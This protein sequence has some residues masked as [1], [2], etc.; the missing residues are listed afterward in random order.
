MYSIFLFLSLFSLVNES[1]FFLC[2]N[3]DNQCK[4]DTIIVQSVFT[5]KN[6][7]EDTLYYPIGYYHKV[8][9]NCVYNN[10]T[11]RYSLQPNIYQFVLEYSEHSSIP[12]EYDTVFTVFP[13]QKVHVFYKNFLQKTATRKDKRINIIVEE[14]F[15]VNSLG[16]SAFLKGGKKDEF[17]ADKNNL[18]FI[19]SFKTSSA[20]TILR[21]K[22]KQRS[23]SKN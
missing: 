6:D 23:G 5:L 8:E 22:P 16:L 2:V 3:I 12:I 4:E 20:S 17:F 10:N 11:F 1:P 18:Q 9:S 13:H 21:L 15:L 7:T 19:R 14:I